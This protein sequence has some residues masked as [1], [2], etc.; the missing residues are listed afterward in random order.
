YFLTL[1]VLLTIMP[2][3]IFAQEECS[4]QVF[5]DEFDYE[6]QP[7]PDLW[8]YETGGGG[9]GNNE[10]QTYTDSRDN[11][12]VSNGTLKIHAKKSESGEWTS[13]RMVTSGKASWKY[14][15]FEIRAKLPEGKGTWPAIWMMP[16]ESVHGTWPKSGEI[17]IMEH[18]GYDPGI[19]HGTIHTEAFNHNDGTQKGGS[20]EV[21]DAQDEFHVYSIEWTPEEITWYM[22]GEQ[23][24]SFSNRNETYKEWPFDQPFFLILNIAIGGNWGGAQGIDPELEEAVMEIDYV[25]VYQDFLP[26]FKVKGPEAAEEGEEVSF[27]AP[28]RENVEYHWDIP[29]DAEFIEGEGTDRI[30]LRW[31]NAS[32]TVGCRMVGE[33]EEK[34]GEVIDVQL[35]KKPMDAPFVVPSLDEKDQPLWE[36]PEQ[37]GENSFS[38]SAFE[39]FMQVDYSVESP[40]SNPRIMYPFSFFGDFSEFRSIE[41]PVKVIDGDAPSVLRLDLVDKNGK[42]NT[43]DLFKI[44]EPV[45]NKHFHI[46]RHTFNGSTAGWRMDEIVEARL[47]VNYGLSGKTGEG[48]FQIGDIRMAPEGFFPD[49]IV[50]E[51][52][53]L[54]VTTETGENGWETNDM[55][56]ENITLAGG[57]QLQIGYTFS[58]GSDE[59]HIQLD[60]DQP[61]DLHEFREMHI[62]FEPDGDWPGTIEAAIIDR[63]GVHNPD[64]LFVMEDFSFSEDNNT[65]SYIFGDVDDGG[66]FLPNRVRALRLW[67]DRESG[68]DEQ[69]EFS[70]ND[71]WFTPKD[72]TNSIADQRRFFDVHV[73]PVPADKFLYFKTEDRIIN[74][75]EIYSVNGRKIA[76]GKMS[77]HENKIDVSNLSNGYFVLLLRSGNGQFFSEKIFIQR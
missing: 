29:E 10:L 19:V 54:E 12:Y 28:S 52:D 2:S 3:F 40:S 76:H 30:T 18:V 68:S 70:I 69:V 57:E 61:V 24:F 16:Q 77:D 64:D 23:Y 38:L 21:P 43:S 25:R 39:D 37:E 17:D 36:V 26:D 41:L 9:W 4:Y 6:G 67:L 31:G 75:W 66:A 73:W 53:R 27:S 33:C 7:D 49:V 13:A 51:G 65:L 35:I 47:Y 63:N 71:I 74:S 72:P 62:E 34:E 60:F 15:R 55:V 14:G 42:V 44:D 50:P 20:I 59:N 46:Y 8:N 5:S 48:V 1:I 58:E 22:D 32:G 11:S 56:S 45:N